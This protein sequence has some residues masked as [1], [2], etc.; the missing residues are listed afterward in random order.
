MVLKA[1]VSSAKDTTH[2]LRG[3]QSAASSA[4]GKGEEI[5]SIKR[6]KHSIELTDV[7]VILLC[8]SLKTLLMTCRAGLAAL[9]PTGS[10]RAS[11]Q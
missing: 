9:T 7:I 8:K 3:V 11:A 5:T 4:D 10:P 6:K 2:D 1:E